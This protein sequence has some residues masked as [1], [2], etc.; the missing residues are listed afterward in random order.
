M[1]PGSTE[2]WRVFQ[3]RVA[4]R[5][6]RIPVCRVTVGETLNGARGNVEVDVV[7][8]FDS[9]CHGF[10]FTVLIECKFWKTRIP[11][12]KLF[13][14]KAR[15][16]EAQMQG[17]SGEELVNNVYAGIAMINDLRDR[18]KRLRREIREMKAENEDR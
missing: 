15:A 16:W 14:L 10:V 8:R 9:P 1:G 5:F 13:A 18:N 11:Q 12:E 2:E 3:E 7:A 17:M 4:D 6:R